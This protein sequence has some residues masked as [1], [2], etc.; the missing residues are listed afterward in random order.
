MPPQGKSSLS[1][2]HETADSSVVS[3]N[4]FEQPTLDGQIDPSNTSRLMSATYAQYTSGPLPSA[5]ELERYKQVDSNLPGKIVEM[6][7]NEQQHRHALETQEANFRETAITTEQNNR[8]V[9]T[10]TGQRFG[11]FAVLAVLGCAI[12]ALCLGH[13][14]AAATITGLN[15]AAVVS[16]FLLGS[17]AAPSESVAENNDE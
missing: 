4:I 14:T 5:A 15:L 13:P 7:V 16:A 3:E 12:L 1:P 9:V 10:K 17:K 6:A 2:T 11:L 8:F